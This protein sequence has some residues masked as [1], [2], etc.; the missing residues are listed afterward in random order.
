[1]PVTRTPASSWCCRAPSRS[2]SR[3]ATRE[4]PVVVHGPGQ[5]TG[6]I[7]MLSA[8]RSLVR[9]R[10]TR[11]GE[12]LAV[13]PRRPARPGAAGLR[14]ERD[15]DARLHPA[16][17]GADRPGA[18][19]PGADRVAPLGRH[20]AAAASSSPATVSRSPTRTWT[21]TRRCRRCWIAS[22]SGPTRCRWCCAAGTATCCSNPSP[23]GLA[24]ALG[25]TAT[26]DPE[27]LRDVVIV[28]A[29]PAG[30]AAAV[31]AAS[32]GAGRAGA[33][34]QR[35]GRPGRHQLAHRELPRLPHRHLGRGAGRA[36]AVP[37]GEVRGRGGHRAHR[38]PPG[39]RQPPLPRLPVRRRRW[40]TPAPSSSPPASATASWTCPRCPASRGPA[41]STAPR[42]WRGSCA[43]ASR[44][45]SSAAAT[46]P[47][48]R[49][50][51]CRGL[52]R[53][54]HILV[55]GPGL[56]DSMS[57]YLIQRIEST[58]NV[59]LR[60]RRIVETLEGERPA[61][62]ASAGGTSRPASAR[63][64]PSAACS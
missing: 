47:G 5:F 16:A 60:T 6:E 44:W 3:W 9:A 32:R 1:M 63:R 36:G 53:H 43:R 12:L 33:G 35:P 11:D 41:S 23:E 40:C 15:P 10:V 8:R 13:G 25:L 17:G 27:E 14:A 58:P 28:G 45:P 31:Y 49:R 52:A 62:S 20:P 7:N 26:L 19:R 54:V 42:T 57:R 61:W 29:G 39:L 21:A 34:E 48:R 50:C 22:T 37:G 38:R 18:Q 55:R 56:A 64:S 46:P 2:C 51:T 59:T 4:E 24:E 30:L